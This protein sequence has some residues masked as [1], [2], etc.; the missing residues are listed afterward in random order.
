MRP[1]NYAPDYGVGL[2]LLK[3]RARLPCFARALATPSP[4]VFTAPTLADNYV[5]ALRRIPAELNL[6]KDEVVGVQ[7]ER[8]V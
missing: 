4:K 5:S 2:I 1:T 7:V 3:K 8:P 6:L